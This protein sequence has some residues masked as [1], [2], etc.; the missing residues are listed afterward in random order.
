MSYESCEKHEG[1]PASNDPNLGPVDPPPGLGYGELEAMERYFPAAAE[2]LQELR[3]ARDK[4]VQ[5]P[6]S[7]CACGLHTIAGGIHGIRWYWA[8][9]ARDRCVLELPNEKCW[10]G[11]LRSEH[12]DQ[13]GHDP[14]AR[15]MAHP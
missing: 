6:R 15:E 11:R 7:R 8:V 1:E 4:P 12:Q 13:A 5:Y 14:V 2:H 3:R 10:C 9:H